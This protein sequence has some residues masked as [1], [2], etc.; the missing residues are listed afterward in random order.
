MEC[1]LGSIQEQKL[2]KNSTDLSDCTVSF[3]CNKAW[4]NRKVKSKDLP[5]FFTPHI[6]KKTY[7][8]DL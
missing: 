6:F 8:Q 4:L 3:E 5:C 1:R 2:N 7:L